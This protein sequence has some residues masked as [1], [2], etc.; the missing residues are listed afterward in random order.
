MK[1]VQ[2]M[3]CRQYCGCYQ[4]LSSWRICVEDRCNEFSSNQTTLRHKR[5]VFNFERVYLLLKSCIIVMRVSY[6]PKEPTKTCQVSCAITMGALLAYLEQPLMRGSS[7]WF[8][9]KSSSCCSI[10]RL[11]LFFLSCASHIAETI[12]YSHG[13]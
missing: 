13:F 7:F 6:I 5:D 3:R 9:G 12:L 2:T 4:P 10:F 1:E 8:P 11:K